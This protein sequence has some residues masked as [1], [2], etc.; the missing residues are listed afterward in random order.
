M[1]PEV[2]ANR[3]IPHLIAQALLIYVSKYF[4]GIMSAQ[5]LRAES[6]KLKNSLAGA[7]L[8]LAEL[9]RCKDPRSGNPADGSESM[10]YGDRLNRRNGVSRTGILSE[11]AVK[12]T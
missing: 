9:N 1:T 5:T 8:H 10:R 2:F 11:E 6:V 7:K 4:C 3:L 12:K